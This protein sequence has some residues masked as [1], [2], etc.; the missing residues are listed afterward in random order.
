MPLTKNPVLA[1]AEST[2]ICRSLRSV[3]MT[4]PSFAAWCSRHHYA[5]CPWWIQTGN[6]LSQH[7]ACP[8]DRQTERCHSVHGKHVAPC[9]VR[10]CSH[11]HVA[12]CRSLLSANPTVMVVGNTL[13]DPR[14]CTHPMVVGAPHLRFYAGMLC[15]Y[16]IYQVHKPCSTV[17]DGAC[18]AT[19]LL[20]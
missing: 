19:H 12:R 13:M 16:A 6:G 4:S 17:D 9:L 14:F 18:R 10:H 8:S 1:N 7:R 5:W 3:L 2:A 20:I 11:A 15:K